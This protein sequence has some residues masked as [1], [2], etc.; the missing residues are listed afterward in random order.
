M[1]PFQYYT[2]ELKNRLNYVLVSF[3]LVVTVNLLHIRTVLSYLQHMIKKPFIYTSL[4][5]AFFSYLTISTLTAAVL[6][7]PIFL[8][9][10]EMFLTPALKRKEHSICSIFWKM[11]WMVSIISMLFSYFIF[12]NTGVSFF[13][14]FETQDASLTIMFLPKLSDLVST[15]VKLLAFGILIS[16]IPLAIFILIDF[17]ALN[18]NKIKKKRKVIISI[19][20][21]IATLMSPPDILSQLITFVFLFMLSEASIILALIKINVIMETVGLEPTTSCLQSR[22]STN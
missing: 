7:T 11:T 2:S 5:E 9:Q 17:E 6:T 12:F 10:A 13:S 15:M 16:V 21:I 18:V 22:R 14:S 4:T 20:L 1:I 19:M 3:L 8:Y